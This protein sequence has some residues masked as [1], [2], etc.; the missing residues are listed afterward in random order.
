MCTGL[1]GRRP[2]EKASY[3]KR[4]LLNQELILSFKIGLTLRETNCNSRFKPKRHWSKEHTPLSKI[5]PFLTHQIDQ[6]DRIK[7]SLKITDPKTSRA[8]TTIEQRSREVSQL[9]PKT[10]Q[11][12]ELNGYSKKKDV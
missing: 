3:Y 5:I 8:R 1:Q 6:Q 7:I 9:I 12:V 4:L 10:F 11:Q 2:K